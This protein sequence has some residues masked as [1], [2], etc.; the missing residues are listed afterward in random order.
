MLL[1]NVR[2]T[3]PWQHVLEPLSG[4][5]NLAMF[6][7]D[8]VALHGEPFNFGPPSSQNYSVGSLVTHM[9]KHW[10]NGRW[11]DITDLKEGPNESSTLKL[12]CDKALNHL[13]WHATWDFEKTVYETVEW[14]R[15]FYEQ[16]E[17]INQLSKSQIQSYQQDASKIG[18]SWSNESV[19]S[20]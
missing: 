6:L 5:L 4:Y 1:R 13:G 11:K 2:A 7:N 14:Y 16:P 3:R 17:L 9:S 12:N 15:I 18:L 8:N 19:R 10:N 20:N